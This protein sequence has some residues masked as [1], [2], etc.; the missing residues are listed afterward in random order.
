[1]ETI[2]IDECPHSA[3]QFRLLYARSWPVAARGRETDKAAEICAAF[4]GG[5]GRF[6]G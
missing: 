1:M 3:A 2:V 6:A 4:V 5:F